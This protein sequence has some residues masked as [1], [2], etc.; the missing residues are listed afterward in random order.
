MSTQPGNRPPYPPIHW[1]HV[2]RQWNEFR[3][4]CRA[5]DLYERYE[6]ESTAYREAD[7]H[8]LT[9]SAPEREQ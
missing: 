9:A 1:T 8:R 7:R 4:S 3:V 6:D 5:C 2:Q